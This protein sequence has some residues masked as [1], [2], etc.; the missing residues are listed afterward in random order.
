[1]QVCHQKRKDVMNAIDAELW[2]NHCGD[3]GEL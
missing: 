3:V 1:M 2:R